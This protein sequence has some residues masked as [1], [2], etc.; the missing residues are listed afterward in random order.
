M[1]IASEITRIHTDTAAVYDARER[2]DEWIFVDNSRKP[3]GSAAIISAA[4]SQ[5][6]V[7]SD[8]GGRDRCRSIY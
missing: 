8:N 3:I 4:N 6:M 7:L 5:P 2:Y 1:S